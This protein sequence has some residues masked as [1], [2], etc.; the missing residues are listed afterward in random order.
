M[1][2][3]MRGAVLSITI[4]CT[5][6]LHGQFQA[7]AA[8]ELGMTADPKTPGA[9]AVYLDFEEIANDPIHYQSYYAR[10]K[11]LRENGK[12]L[13][14][15]ELPYVRGNRKVTNIKGRTIHSDGTVISLTVKPED[16]MISKTGATQVGKMVFT[17][18]NKQP[19][20]SAAVD[21]KGAL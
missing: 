8:D 19:P 3:Y 7:P 2:I 9:A 1:H 4:L 11:V 16:L 20:F 17:L 13:A 21:V 6:L 5:P 12:E 10:I 14:P 15:V 18:S